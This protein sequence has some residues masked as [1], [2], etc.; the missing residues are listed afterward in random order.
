MSRPTW[1]LFLAAALAAQTPP[2]AASSRTPASDS[3]PQTPSSVI[4]VTTHIV[5]VS[6]VVHD[7]K[8]EP[9]KDLK[10]E[11]FVLTDKGEEQRIR[12]FSMETA[13]QSTTP[14]L[15]ALPVGIVS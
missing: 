5:Q 4:K 1:A 15:S 12:L 10:K 11:D 2:P 3:P 14:A 7:K 13:S 6:V 8:G 9:V